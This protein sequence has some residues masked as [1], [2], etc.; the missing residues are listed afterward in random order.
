MVDRI[1]RDYQNL[2]KDSI[3][4]AR[5]LGLDLS[6]T[7]TLVDS[8]DIDPFER[9]GEA[10]E[11][12][13]G[14]LMRPLADAMDEGLEWPAA[15]PLPVVAWN[16]PENR[17]DVIDGNHRIT[18]AKRVGYERIPVVMI[19]GDAFDA[20]VNAEDGIE[21]TTWIEALGLVDAIIRKNL[22]LGLPR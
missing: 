5:R 19:D 18:A 6:A 12:N 1:Q 4:K 10:S 2:L 8:E 11:S 17:F 22:K 20:M 9:S 3:R 13:I 21:G 7:V 15:M 14:M 16:D